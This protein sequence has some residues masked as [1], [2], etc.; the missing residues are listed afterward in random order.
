MT[1]LL[2]LDWLARAA[3]RAQEDPLLIVA[4]L[5]AKHTDEQPHGRH[6]Q[7]EVWDKGAFMTCLARHPPSTPTTYLG[8]LSFWDF[9]EASLHRYD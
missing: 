5:F 7:G 4:G 3:H 8:S 6:K 9:M 1:P 2:G